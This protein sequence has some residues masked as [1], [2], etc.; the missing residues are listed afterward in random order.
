MNYFSFLNFGLRTNLRQG[1]GRG[2]T[3]LVSFVALAPRGRTTDPQIIGVEVLRP[4]HLAAGIAHGVA[5]ELALRRA[6]AEALPI[7]QNATRLPSRTSSIFFD[8]FR[9][10]QGTGGHSLFISEKVGGG[11]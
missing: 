4:V 8:R 6:I 1:Q 9:S 11:T 10:C 5:D 2:A 3:L 7:V